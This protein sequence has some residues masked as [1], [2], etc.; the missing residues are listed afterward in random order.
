MIRPWEGSLYRLG[1]DWKGKDPSK[2]VL[3][4]PHSIRYSRP[5]EPDNFHWYAFWADEAGGA[6][7][8]LD[9][10]GH[11]RLQRQ[12]DKGYLNRNSTSRVFFMNVHHQLL[13]GSQ[14][15]R[16]FSNSKCH[17]PNLIMVGSYVFGPSIQKH[18]SSRRGLTSLRAGLDQCRKF[19]IV[20]LLLSLQ[21]TPFVSKNRP[22]AS[23]KCKYIEEIFHKCCFHL[24]PRFFSRSSGVMRSISKRAST[25]CRV[26]WMWKIAGKY[27]RNSR[28]RMS[29][30][31]STGEAQGS[32]ERRAERSEGQDLT[33]WLSSSNVTV[34]SAFF[35]TILPLHWAKCKRWPD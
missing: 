28:F 27:F 29:W 15:L 30:T 35:S 18:K 22:S 2:K 17:K 34:L 7:R 13:P 8:R 10:A 1:N 12:P 33:W 14:F 11:T 31:Y 5:Q 24:Y 3:Y 25:C 21:I 32:R 23:R 6:R 4:P 9:V 26:S 19:S 20:L 16:I